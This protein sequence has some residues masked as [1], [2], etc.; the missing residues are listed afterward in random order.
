MAAAVEAL[1][2]PGVVA[3]GNMRIENSYK[4]VSQ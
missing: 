2:E 4:L 3:I 1:E